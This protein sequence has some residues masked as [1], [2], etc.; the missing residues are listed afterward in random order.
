MARNL[1]E[2]SVCLRLAETAS[3]AQKELMGRW[4]IFPTGPVEAHLMQQIKSGL[5]GI[6]GKSVIYEVR[7]VPVQL[8]QKP[9]RPTVGPW[10]RRQPS[11][12]VCFPKSPNQDGAV[13]NQN[14]PGRS[15]PAGSRQRPQKPCQEFKTS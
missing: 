1:N 12:A 6:A 8:E 11:P 4:P 10:Q 14:I 7:C 3:R 9:H 2:A 5:Q 15:L 13:L